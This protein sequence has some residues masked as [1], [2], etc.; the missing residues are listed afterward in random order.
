MVEGL[1]VAYARNTEIELFRLYSYTPHATFGPLL[2]NLNSRFHH[3]LR[4][5]DTKPITDLGLP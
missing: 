2:V 5:S 1:D 4:Q 3:D